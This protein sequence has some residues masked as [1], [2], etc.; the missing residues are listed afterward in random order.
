MSERAEALAVEFE[1]AN[2]EVIAFVE[3]CSD[4]IWTAICPGEGWSVATTGHHIGTGH[5]GIAGFAAAIGAGGPLPPITMDMI[6]EGNA[7]HAREFAMVDRETVIEKLRTDG[8]QAAAIVRGLS[9]DQ[10]DRSGSFFGNTMTAE[11]V[12]SG[13]LIGHPREHLNNMRAAADS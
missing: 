12:I 1:Q 9:D 7:Q 6:N 10:L 11:Q 8:A 5:T 3:S 2:A 4:R 13:I